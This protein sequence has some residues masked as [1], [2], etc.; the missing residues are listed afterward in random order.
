MTAAP[1]PDRER[2]TGI[3][4]MATILMRKPWPER[5]PETSPREFIWITFQRTTR[6]MMDFFLGTDF[7]VGESGK[8][9]EFSFLAEGDYDCVKMIH[10]PKL[11]GGSLGYDDSLFTVSA[12]RQGDRHPEVEPFPP[13]QKGHWQRVAFTVYSS[14]EAEVFLNGEKIIERTMLFSGG[15]YGVSMAAVYLWHSQKLHCG[16]GGA[17][18]RTS[19]H[20]RFLKSMTA[21]M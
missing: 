18:K 3:E 7:S 9:I 4:V 6:Q 19:G 13:I 20:G 21:H 11:T 14:G 15:S 2:I 12:G 16:N 8:T 10:R 5:E 1:A 17:E